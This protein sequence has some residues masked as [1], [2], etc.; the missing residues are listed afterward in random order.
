MFSSLDTAVCHQRRYNSI[1][2]GWSSDVDDKPSSVYKLGHP[3]ELNNS[4]DKCT[5]VGRLGPVY[6]YDSSMNR[7]AC[8]RLR[9]V[10]DHRCTLFLASNWDIRQGFAR[11]DEGQERGTDHRLRRT[12]Q[13]RSARGQW[14]SSW[15]HSSTR[16][17]EYPNRAKEY[18][19]LSD[20]RN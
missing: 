18:T 17:R 15:V 20:E 10:D 9:P 16:R 19:T 12:L 4:I 6:S 13:W 7:W 2:S 11:M 5:G 8:D 3:K 1:C 14:L